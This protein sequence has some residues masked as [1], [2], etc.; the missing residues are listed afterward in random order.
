M[1]GIKRPE[2]EILPQIGP[3]A[4]AVG[5]S[6]SEHTETTEYAGRITYIEESY[7]AYYHDGSTPGGHPLVEDDDA[8]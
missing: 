1:T 5:Y 2:T 3:V 7:E 8:D 6:A 4:A